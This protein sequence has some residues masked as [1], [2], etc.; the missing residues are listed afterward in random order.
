MQATHEWI[1]GQVLIP[2]LLRKAPQVRAVLDR[3]GLRGCGGRLGPAESVEFFAQLHD[4]PLPQ[5]VEELR[6]A[7]DT[8]VVQEK[9]KPRWVD[10][11]YRPFFIAGILVTLTAGATWGAYL[12]VRIA[13][14]GS[15]SA[16]GLHEVNAH[17]HAQIFGWVGLFVMGFAYQAFPRFKH[18]ELA[19]PGLALAS[20][21][22]MLAGLIGRS[23]GEPLAASV[24]GMAA[25][26][27]GSSVLEVVAVALCAA[28]VLATWRRS[29]K[30]FALPD[31]FIMAALFWF[32]VQAVYEA[33]YLAATLMAADAGELIPL[34]ATWQGAL[35]D[36]QIHGFALLMILGVSLR[37]LPSVYGLR[38]SGKA[39]AVLTLAAVNAAVIG[40]ASGLIL[41]RSGGPVWRGVWYGSVLVL[42]ATL[43]VFVAGA[44][45]FGR[46]P[47]QDRSLKFV[48]AAY[49]WLLFSLAMLV[50][51]PVYQHLLLPLLAP[52]SPA[53]AIGFSHAYYGA[54]RHA[55]TVGFVSLMIVGVAGRVVPTLNGLDLARLP[56]LWLPFVLLNT[57]CALRVVAQT[58]TDVTDTAFPLVGVSGWLEVL[59][60]TLWGAHLIRIM[61]GWAAEQGP[62]PPAVEAGVPIRGEHLVS[63]VLEADPALLDVFVAFGFR[64]LANPILRRTL[65]RGITIEAAC[66]FLGVQLQAL[67]D[68][69]NAARTRHLEGTATHACPP[70]GPAAGPS[71]SC[72]EHDRP[73]PCC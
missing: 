42:A 26:A 61:T 12:L 5:L 11:I 69:L 9:A 57:G 51:L 43:A 27:V 2:D 10:A 28:V 25:V 1:D 71:C 8:T 19:W 35:R 14:T 39:L 67:L 54:A 60:L 17:G 24:S 64:L 20:F 33:V 38:S 65:A 36:I 23:I 44:G 49:A 29:E 15:F 13:A 6:E 72:C 32:V 21:C 34:V 63:E 45:I 59:G 47:R 62:P 41:M 16:A 4:V 48:R 3:Y 18:A 55:V 37:I 30:P 31:A 56:R 50:L 40:E 53:V 66:G 68:A 73:T 58:L 70:K 46:A 52:D 7:S 22:A